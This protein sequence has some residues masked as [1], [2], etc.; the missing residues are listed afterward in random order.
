[1]RIVT[2]S[3]DQESYN[4]NRRGYHSI[5]AQII[6]DSKNRILNVVADWPGSV[7]ESRIFQSSYVGM[8]FSRGD[9]DGI[10]LGDSGYACSN[11]LLTPLFN[12]DTRQQVAYNTA[13][14]RTRSVVER[15]I[16]E[17]FAQKRFRLVSI[18]IRC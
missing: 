12:A 3:G 7:H 5:N 11:Y 15:T 14:A 13:H 4:V 16:G 1:M 10:L 9:M 6:C 17:C 8:Q 2:P 18:L